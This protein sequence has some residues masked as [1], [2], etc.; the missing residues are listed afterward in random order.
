MKNI[1]KFSFLAGIVIA[2]GLLSNT[3]PANAISFDFSTNIQG[4]DYNG[5]LDFINTG[6][7]LAPLLD[8]NTNLTKYEGNQVN[9]VASAYGGNVFNNAPLFDVTPTSLNLTTNGGLTYAGGEKLEFYQGNIL[10]DVVVGSNTMTY[11]PGTPVPFEFNST[12][13]IALGFPLFIG[14]RMLKKRKAL[15]NSTRELPEI[16]N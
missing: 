14:L 4:Y 3:K 5:S 1:S 9:S 16:I 6:T 2:A 8:S 13:G 7:N 15:K 10:I 12:E 11:S